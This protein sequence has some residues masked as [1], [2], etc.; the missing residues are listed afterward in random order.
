[1]TSL[2]N[3][4]L[5]LATVGPQFGFAE[6]LDAALRHG[7]DTISPWRHHYENIGA[8][9]A[10]TELRARGMRVDNVCRISG[11]GPSAEVSQWSQAMDEAKATIAEAV[12]LGARAVIYPGGGVSDNA[13]GIEAV[14]GRIAE[15]LAQIVPL[16][17]AAGI[18]IL[19]EPLHPMVAAD[20]GAIS[21]LGFAFELCDAVGE[22][23]GVMV[24]SYNV[25]WDP[26]LEASLERGRRWVSGFQVSDWLMTTRHT[27]FDRGMVGDGVIDFARFRSLVDRTG[28][29]GPI[30]VEVLSEKNWWTREL[31]EVLST[32]RERVNLHLGEPK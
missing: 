8:G 31:D 13:S 29:A 30:E 27:A 17:R 21:T 28:Y 6:T 3:L 25:W 9:V 24:D 5:N 10:A 14:R 26:A 1:M 23:V 32:A 2:D 18:L 22:G 20:R 12:E 15:G 7:F 11:F 19:V 16:A 4:S